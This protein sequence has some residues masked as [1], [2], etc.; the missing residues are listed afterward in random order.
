MIYPG[1]SSL[2]LRRQE[3]LVGRCL[4]KNSSMS[5]G[6]LFGA[7]CWILQRLSP[8]RYGRIM[9]HHSPPT[10]RWSC[11]CLPTFGWGFWLAGEGSTRRKR[12]WR[13]VGR[14][15]RNHSWWDPHS[16]QLLPQKSLSAACLPGFTCL[17]SPSLFFLSSHPP[18]LPLSCP[19]ADSAQLFQAFRSPRPDALH[20]DPHKKE[21][22]PIL[23][24]TNKC[25]CSWVSALISSSSGS[26]YA[27][28]QWV[29]WAVS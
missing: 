14:G 3:R 18:A 29:T 25:A 20:P 1:N 17:P 12:R 21:G 11:V 15:Q 10:D 5:P 23:A 6:L 2:S 22:R 7:W 28:L 26:R 24:L 8:H 19:P 9:R 4:F 16:N 27:V 13:S